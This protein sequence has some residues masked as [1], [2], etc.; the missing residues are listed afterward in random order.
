MI[1]EMYKLLNEIFYYDLNN[2]SYII[3]EATIEYLS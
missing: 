2:L 1:V 3:K